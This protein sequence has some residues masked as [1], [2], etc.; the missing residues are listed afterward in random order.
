YDTFLFSITA[1]RPRATVTAGPTTIQVGGIVTLS[2]YVETSAEF[3]NEV[4][5]TQQPKWPQIF[6]GE[7]I[8]LTCEVQGRETS[9]WTYE[10]RRSGSFIY[11]SQEKNLTFSVYE[12]NSGDYRCLCLLKD[13]SHSSTQWSEP[14]TLSVL[15]KPKAQL[16]ADST[17]LPVGGSV[18]L[19]CS[20]NSS[21]SFGWKYF[22]YRG[23][24][25]PEPLTTRD[26]VFL[27]NG[28]ITVSYKGLFWCRGGRGE[29]V[30]YTHFSDHIS[31]SK[32]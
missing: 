6:S 30:Y 13:D 2:C 31:I 26:A 7:T 11:Q 10:W 5:V 18:T 16:S 15:R 8:T 28:Q 1:D 24:K 3:S 27:S 21:S 20:V 23:E 25:S 19:T 22:W 17:E 9:E 29:P 12:S 14:I 4:V 32:S